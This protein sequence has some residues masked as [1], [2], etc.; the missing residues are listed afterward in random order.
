MNGTITGEEV[1]FYI[2]EGQA[3]FTGSGDTTLTAPDDGYYKGV[4]VFQA[5]NNTNTIVITGDAAAGG[6]GT[7]YAPAAQIDFSGNATTSFQFIS[8][9]FYAHGNSTLIVTFD[10]GF[11]ADVPY[12]WLAE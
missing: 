6:W 1:M 9:T 10:S 12:I 2:E 8:D 4:L 5:R 7:I 3:I 11:L